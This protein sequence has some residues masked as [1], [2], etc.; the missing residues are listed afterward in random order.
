MS[1]F[2]N[3]KACSRCGKI[4]A[5]VCSAAIVMTAIPAVSTTVSAQITLTAKTTTYLNLRSGKGV[6]Y[7]VKT[8]IPENA[9]VTILDKSDKNWIKVRLSDGTEG[10]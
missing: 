9:T 1:I 6:N 2:K 3:K 4:V 5:A 7:S 10:Y 8:V